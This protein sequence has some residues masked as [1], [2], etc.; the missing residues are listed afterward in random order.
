VIYIRDGLRR[1]ER[2]ETS[3]DGTPTL[4][5]A[6]STYQ[7]DNQITSRTYGNGLLEMRSYDLQGRLEAQDLRNPTGP[8]EARSYAY[9]PSGNLTRRSRQAE[10][11]TYAYDDLD[12]LVQEALEGDSPHRPTMPMTRTATASDA[13]WAPI[14]MTPTPSRQ[15]PTAWRSSRP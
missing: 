1:I 15:A 13:R 4:V 3:I 11:R 7:A 6:S 10:D 9:D 5:L 2:I 12:R 14:S 8:I